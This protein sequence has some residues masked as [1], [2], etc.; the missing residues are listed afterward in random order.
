MIRVCLVGLGKT[1]KEIAKVILEHEN[2]K[3]VSVVCSSGSKN[4]GKSLDDV[5]GCS[6]SG[7]IID[8]EKNLEQVIFKTK[9]DVLVDFSTPAA[10]VRN[11]KIFSKMKVNIVVGTTGFSDFSLKK[12]FVLTRKY[13]NAICYAPNITL[14]VNVL[15]LLTNLAASILNN[16]DFQITEVHHKKKVDIPS[17]TAIKI[18]R[19]IKKGLDSAGVRV[20]ESTIPINAVRAGGVVGKHEVMIVGEDDKI[21][22]S[23]ESFSRRAFALGA[24]KAIEFIHDKVGYYEMN[25]VLNLHKVLEDY[26]EKEQSKKK[27][28]IKNFRRDVEDSPVNV[29]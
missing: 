26:L 3:L 10:T 8:G 6:N 7:I 22:I 28:K 11:A 14:G 27:R 25:D 19:E 5:I 2:M 4:L 12:L 21:E 18:A 23:H 29:V 20:R 9:P 15:M 13:H 1:G 24:I 16:Y 17:G